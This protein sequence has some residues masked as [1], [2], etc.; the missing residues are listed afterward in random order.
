LLA[1]I[2]LSII[3]P[4]HLPAAAA[5]LVALITKPA[6]TAA[7]AAEPPQQPAVTTVS[8]SSSTI[9]WTMLSNKNKTILNVPA[10]VPGCIH[11]DLLAAKLI[12]EPNYGANQDLQQ[13]IAQ[14]DFNYATATFALPATLLAYRNVD[15]VL[16][17]IDTISAITF[18]NQPVLNARNMH[19]T[20]HVDVKALVRS[21][22]NSMAANFTGPVPGSLAAQAACGPI[23]GDA[24]C[25]C[26]HAWPGPAPDQMLINGYIRK[27]Q[28][29]FGWDFAPTTGTSGITKEPKLVG[30]DV[31]LIR[32]VVVTTTPVSGDMDGAGGTNGAG[33]AA[34]GADEACGWTVSVSVRLWST[35]GT[36]TS[37]TISK[38]SADFDGAPS[39]S[40]TSVTE[41]AVGVG[42][43]VATLTFHVPATANVERWWPNGYG[44]QPLYPLTIT[45]TAGDPGSGTNTNTST[46]TGKGKGTENRRAPASAPSQSSKVVQVGF[47]TIEINQPALP[48]GYG[49]GHLFQYAVNSKLIYARGSNWVPAQTLQTRVTKQTVQRHFDAF[50]TAHFNLVRVWG[51]GVYAS[52][53][54]MELADEAGIIILQ[55]F[56]FGD[57]FYPTNDAFLT[58]VAA[59]VRDNVWRMGSHASLGVWCGNN[60]M[61]SFYPVAAHAYYSKLFFATVLNNVSAVDP[62]RQQISSTPSMGNETATI[63]YNNNDCKYVGPASVKCAHLELRGDVHYYARGATLSNC[64]DTTVAPR[65]R[66]V[67]EFGA[68]SWPSF[69]TME[70][71]LNPD[72]SDYSFNG[73]VPVSMQQHPGGQYEITYNVEANWLWPDKHANLTALGYRDELWMT[74]VAAAECYTHLV[75][76]WR[77]QTDEYVNT[78]YPLS[79]L[80]WAMLG[81]NAGVL[82]WQA[83]DTWPGPSWSQ[84]EVGADRYKVGYYAFQRA[85]QPV[86]VAGQL[87]ADT[88]QL[89]IYFSRSNYGVLASLNATL[90][91]TAIKWSGGAAGPAFEIAVTLPG[92]HRSAKVFT[93]SLASVMSST[94]CA[95]RNECVLQIEVIQEESVPVASNKVYLSK[96]NEV[97]TMI[98]DPGLVVSNIVQ[99]SSNSGGGSGGTFNIT[100]TAKNVPA[101]VVWLETKLAGRF[102][103]NGMLMLLEREVQVQFY[104]DDETVTDELLA[105]TLTV[106]SLVDA[107]HGYCS[108]STG[109]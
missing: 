65:A 41:V 89:A 77:S 3:N 79:P 27:E 64:W 48:E 74:Q 87:N 69:L 47:R 104:T 50:R 12:G 9:S 83:D 101:A 109:A 90:R 97:T 13:W 32:D 108:S 28:Q 15:L 105:A 4:L 34:G 68:E 70:P 44:K 52:D 10:T 2:S 43:T 31:A 18:N 103:D 67:T 49:D 94:G 5:M 63:P 75:E 42:E 100:V 21:T 24:N 95:A 39:A 92:Q 11:T 73:S 57:S 66:M 22:G 93:A 36:P 55:D 99:L 17:G 85:Y 20:Y 59:E 6:A 45:L 46:G 33:S 25:T 81:G 91:L 80:G 71:Y 56:M 60:E 7:A 35:H 51:G 19:R 37:S 16:E 84:V 1:A 8:L 62:H 54:F 106:R 58:D 76:Y 107:A 38:L 26:P 14:D 30:Y 96:L 72:G 88:D 82:Y 102:S 40:G 61:A 29:S 53:D 23:C 86:L 78:T 98:A